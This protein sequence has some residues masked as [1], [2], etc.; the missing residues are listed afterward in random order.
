MPPDFL[1]PNLEQQII[2][3]I[4]TSRLRKVERLIDSCEHCK[5]DG[6]DMPF[7]LILD[8]ITR[9]DPRV[10]DYILEEPAKCPNCRREILE[11]Q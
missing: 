6:A 2:V 8:R 9:S 4:D 7:E 1:D 11:R 5:E 10:T 3:L